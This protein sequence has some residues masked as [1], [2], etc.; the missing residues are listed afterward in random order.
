MNR[1]SYSNSMIKPPIK[2]ISNGVVLC[3]ATLQ[4]LACYYG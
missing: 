2:G 1:S 3:G 4:V